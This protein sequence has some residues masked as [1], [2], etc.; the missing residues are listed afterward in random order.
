MAGAPNSGKSVQLRSMFLD[1]RFGTGGQIPT[2]RNLRNTYE[3]SPGRR[4]YLRLTSPHE[5]KENL[6]EFLNKIEENTG[7]LGRWSVASAVQID[8]AYR[9]PRLRDVVAAIDGRFSPQRIQVAILSPDR[10]GTVLIGAP[11]LMQTLQEVPSC[12][13]LCIDAR[14]RKDN[15]LFLA[16]TFD[17]EQGS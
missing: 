10:H 12:E 11:N 8:S 14:S 9:M 15:G 2:A 7:G 5:S 13:V 16:S 4:L 6:D 1:L 17:S 3:L